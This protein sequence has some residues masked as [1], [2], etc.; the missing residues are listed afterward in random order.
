M[1]V[2]RASRR[3][4]SAGNPLV[5]HA[6]DDALQK[7][8]RLDAYSDVV[9]KAE[10]SSIRLATLDFQVQPEYFAAQRRRKNKPELH[11]DIN[12]DTTIFDAKSGFAGIFL[13]CETGA[14]AREEDLVRCKAV[15]LVTYRNLLGCEEEASKAFLERVG[16]FAC[17]PYFRSL[18]SSLD[19]LAGTEMPILPVL[20]QQAKPKSQE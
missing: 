4:K 17:Y 9:E 19:W 14:K 12:T 18:F 6:G 15:F 8:A 10:L 1:K 2:K 16:K 11:L 3:P 7:Q 5:P 20:K 13:S